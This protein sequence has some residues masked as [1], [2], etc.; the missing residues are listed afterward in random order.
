MVLVTYLNNEAD[1]HISVKIS[2]Q[3][4]TEARALF[5]P[6]LIILITDEQHRIFKRAALTRGFVFYFVKFVW[7]FKSN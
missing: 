2:R 6:V 1:F 5:L 4:Q 3:T 7:D